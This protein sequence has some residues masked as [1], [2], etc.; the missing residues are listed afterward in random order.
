[1]PE[2]PVP[3]AQQRPRRRSTAISFPALPLSLSAT[4]KRL[5]FPHPLV[6]WKWPLALSAFAFARRNP[7]CAFGPWASA[8]YNLIAWLQIIA[9]DADQDKCAGSKAAH[10]RARIAGRSGGPPDKV[11]GVAGDHR[12]LVRFD[13]EDF[14]P[15]GI[16]RNDGF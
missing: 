14:S 16:G 4:E 7:A 10:A 6:R 11:Y 3:G 2:R 5:R 12:L 9:L 8:H 13:D 1:M 15:A